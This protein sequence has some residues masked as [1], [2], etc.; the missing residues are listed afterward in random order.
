M[1]TKV[2]YIHFIDEPSERVRGYDSIDYQYGGIS[3]YWDEPPKKIW[4]NLSTIR[5][6]EFYIED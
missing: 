3:F 5:S 1:T 4:Y 2:V 6:M